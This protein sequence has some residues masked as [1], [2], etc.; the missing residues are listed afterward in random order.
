MIISGNIWSTDRREDDIPVMSQ[1]DHRFMKL[2]ETEMKKMSN[3]HLSA[4]LPLKDLNIMFESN[5]SQALQRAHLLVKQLQKTPT[6]Q[7]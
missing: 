2:M 5:I 1:K 7:K 3:N 6:K 4:P